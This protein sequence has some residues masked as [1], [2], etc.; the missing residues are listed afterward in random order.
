MVC[1]SAASL[2]DPQAMSSPADSERDRLDSPRKREAIELFRG[3]PPR[4]DALSAALSFWQDPRWRRALVDAV[5]PRPGER[6]LDVATGTGM[7]AAELVRRCEC[8]VV[9]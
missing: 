3:L 7:V 6:V 5:A 9:G 8:T 4:Y 2:S 1:R